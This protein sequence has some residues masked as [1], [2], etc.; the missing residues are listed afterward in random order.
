MS[1]FLNFLTGLGGG[2]IRAAD[3]ASKRKQALETAKINAAI[4]QAQLQATTDN[5][6]LQFYGQSA[7]DYKDALDKADEAISKWDLPQDREAEAARQRQKIGFYHDRLMT[8]MQAP[9]VKRRGLSAPPDGLLPDWV[10]NPNSKYIP[11]GAN[12]PKPGDWLT[13]NTQ[14][15]GLPLS[16]KEIIDS[17]VTRYAP[18]LRTANDPAVVDQVMGMLPIHPSH[19]PFA[20]RIKNTLLGMVGANKLG[21]LG[22]VQQPAPGPITSGAGINVDTI[23][24]TT[25]PGRLGPSVD[26]NAAGLIG[27]ANAGVTIPA[28][29]PTG[30]PAPTGIN[31]PAPAD[32][33]VS[34]PTGMG[35]QGGTTVGV[36]AGSASLQGD[37][38]NLGAMQGTKPSYASSPFAPKGV[39]NLVTG[40]FINPANLIPEYGQMLSKYGNQISKPS[41][42]V[43]TKPLTQEDKTAA[44]LAQQSDPSARISE[45][46]SVVNAGINDARGRT[47]GA[48]SDIADISK[49]A[50]TLFESMP[51]KVKVWTPNDFKTYESGQYRDV[52]EQLDMARFYNENEKTISGLIKDKVE[53]LGK[54]HAMRTADAK[55]PGELDK[56][57]IDTIS[58]RI[59][60]ISKSALLGPEIRLK[61]AEA[62]TAY[63]K[64]IYAVADITSEIASREAGTNA[65]KRRIA[66]EELKHRTE[67]AVGPLKTVIAMSQDKIKTHKGL[68]NT[69]EQRN[70]NHTITMNT[71]SGK[72]QLIFGQGQQTDTA[73]Q[74]WLKS[75]EGMD[76]KDHF[77]SVQGA[78]EEN[79]F[80]ILQANLNP[81]DLAAVQ[82]YR[83]AVMDKVITNQRIANETEKLTNEQGRLDEVGTLVRDIYNAGLNLSDVPVNAKKR[84]DAKAAEEKKKKK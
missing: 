77:D 56:Q 2:Y 19:A 27:P 79:A 73:L 76:L 39:R 52:K 70:Q 69:Y 71:A 38:S 29:R 83:T 36:G 59:D 75:I 57:A 82:Q 5:N 54:L 3:L 42:A 7:K 45:A 6:D 14:Y 13:T 9:G 46:S 23:S 17:Y 25:T 49:K 1:D 15:A 84:A 24:G 12:V 30:V 55:L 4:R 10:K 53:V 44:S 81:A 26:N 78:A 67:D 8:S 18:A 51:D 35:T 16:E 47:A 11:G 37:T 40:A 74:N 80:K 61:V 66:L 43:P 41:V 22:N 60:A 50:F 21:V 31:V 48:V 32:M 34:A 64:A 63:V 68:I 28:L 65:T 62:H 72:I 58:A 20:G 33:G